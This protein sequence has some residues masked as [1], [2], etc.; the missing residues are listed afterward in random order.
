MSILEPADREIRDKNTNNSVSMVG[1]E[2]SHD[3]APDP[4]TRGRKAP[5]TPVGTPT[6][7]PNDQQGSTSTTEGS[8]AITTTRR[9]VVRGVMSV[10]VASIVMRGGGF[11]AQVVAGYLLTAGDFGLFAAT[12]GFTTISASLLSAL[13]P[14]FIE[15]LASSQP[16]DALWR[17]IL[18]GLTLTAAA[19]WIGAAP[20]AA[21]LGRPDAASLFR[22]MALTLPLQFAQVIGVARLSAQLRFTESSKILTFSALARH[23]SLIVFA[24]L[25]FGVTSL[26]L[27]I[28]VEA[29][30][31]LFLLR[32][33]T[34]PFPRLIGPVRGVAGRYGATLGW[35]GLSAL[36]LALSINGDYTFI[37]PLESVAVVGFYFFG[38]QLSGA[39]AQPFTMAAT[40]VLV[41]SFASVAEYPERTRRAFTEAISLLLITA[42]FMFGILA[43]TAGPIIDFIWSGNWNASIAVVALMSIGTPF[44]ILQPTC[45]SLLQATAQWRRLAVIMAV[46]AASAVIPAVIGALVGGVQAIAVGASLGSI[47]GGSLAAILVGNTIG[48]GWRQ[49]LFTL[50]RSA[51]APLAGLAAAF[52]LIPGFQVSVPMSIVRIGI[53]LFAAVPAALALYG[54]ALAEMSSHFRPS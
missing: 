43:L 23:G 4:L 16:V 15:R 31:Q 22:L 19:I 27:P 37:S 1:G 7:S 39:L 11:F 52:V 26:V 2:L 8:P 3:S 9:R 48:I 10:A 28:Y 53:Y 34:G 54:E 25:G 21:L 6:I 47:M 36:G 20:I 5:S 42:G 12:L 51:A 41:P 14:L 29:V 45:Y 18:L 44:R 30:L 32:R 13:R 38:Y 17:A 40:S 50:F 49:I 24:V 46:G 33:A 35:I